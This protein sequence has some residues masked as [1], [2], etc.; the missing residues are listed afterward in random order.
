MSDDE[1]ITLTLTGK[2]SYSVDI[3]L[4]R[5]VQVLA[6]LTSDASAPSGAAPLGAALGGPAGDTRSPLPQAVL[7]P[8]QAL[9]AS[10]AKI[11]SEKI[12]AFAAL[13]HRQSGRDT[14]T[15]DDVRPLFKQAR[16]AAPGNLNRDLSAAIANGWVAEAEDSGEYYVTGKV[17]DVLET[18]FDGL[19]SGKSPS[20]RTRSSGSRRTRKTPL[21]VPE[22]FANADV[23]PTMDG[24]INFHQVKVKRDKHL[25]AVNAAKLLGVEAVAAQELV[26]LTDRL[27]EV[28]PSGD[29]AAHYRGNL[30]LGYVNKNS[31][32]KVRITPAGE[33]HL[34]EL[35]AGNGK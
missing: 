11:N 13:V 3:T 33:A 21:P 14:F 23:S 27:G 29:M 5:A 25:W 19:R 22:V 6:L 28:I 32:G 35:T 20:S 18:G 12:V 8:K 1:D 17:S 24:L 26:W 7:T 34:K 30:K 2:L 31:Q 16:E 9:E 15:L 10:G 4:A